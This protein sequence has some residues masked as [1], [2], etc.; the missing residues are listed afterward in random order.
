VGGASFHDIE[1]LVDRAADDGV[2]EL[3]RILPPEEVEPNECGG[4]RTK[5]ARFHAGEG[6]RVAQLRPVA[7]DRG[8]AQERKRLRLQASEAKPDGAR[9]ALRAD[10]EEAGHVLDGRVGSLPCHRFEHRA[11]EERVS[12]AR[13]ILAERYARGEIG[14]DEYR[15]RLGNLAQ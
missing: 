5:L 11:D 10:F 4:G 15:E 7:E 3:E 12:Y 2:E 6:G 13:A 9:D 14:L 8:R 1:R